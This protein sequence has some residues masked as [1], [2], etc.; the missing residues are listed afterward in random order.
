[1]KRARTLDL[2]R[3]KKEHEVNVGRSRCR[4]TGKVT[5]RTAC[6]FISIRTSRGECNDAISFGLYT[7][8]HQD[9]MRFKAKL[10]RTVIFTPSLC[11]SCTGYLHARRSPV[12]LDAFALI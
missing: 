12:K 6:P 9:C 3:A 10:F 8:S 7:P 1:M 11:S 2:A 4:R 5:R